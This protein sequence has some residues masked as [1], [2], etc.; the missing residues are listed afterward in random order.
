MLAGA[1]SSLFAFVSF[2]ASAAI[3][4]TVETAPAIIARHAIVFFMNPP[5]RYSYFLRSE[6]A[7]QQLLICRKNQSSAKT[8]L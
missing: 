8:P 4:V 7:C 3:A 1:R 6:D 5:D 2:F